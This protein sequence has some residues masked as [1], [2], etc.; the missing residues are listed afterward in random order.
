MKDEM[1]IKSSKLNKRKI[2]AIKRTE[3]INLEI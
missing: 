1:I 2:D 3:F